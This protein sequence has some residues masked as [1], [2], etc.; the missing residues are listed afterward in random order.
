MLKVLQSAPRI[1]IIITDNNVRIKIKCILLIFIQLFA[2]S[3]KRHSG[4]W[5]VLM[6][7][8]ISFRTTLYVNHHYSELRQL[9]RLGKER[10]QRLVCVAVGYCQL[11]DH[12]GT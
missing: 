7:N 11:L 1:G 8:C 6:C 4:D 3:I 5:T 10:C 2:L 9:E 12:L